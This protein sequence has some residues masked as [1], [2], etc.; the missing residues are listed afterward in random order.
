[1]GA[2][3]LLRRSLAELSGGELQRAFLARALIN[4]PEIIFL[5]EPATGVDFLAK[6]DLCDLL[7]SYQNEYLGNIKPTIVMITH[8][9]ASARYHAS[10][11]LIINRTIHG[12][13]LPE[14]VM[15]E[16]HFQKAFGH[17][18]HHHSYL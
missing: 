6:N 4:K 13:G 11:V 1:M 9:L 5:D 14:E 12:L 8:D 18:G 2:E 15:N 7:E 16:N 10:K 17:V 3:K